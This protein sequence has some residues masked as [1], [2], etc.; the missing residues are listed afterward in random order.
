MA[1]I[2]LHHHR[3]KKNGAWDETEFMAA[4]AVIRKQRE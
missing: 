1:H 3:V 4:F 2:R